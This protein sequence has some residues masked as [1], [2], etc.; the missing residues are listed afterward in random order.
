MQGSQANPGYDTVIGPEGLERALMDLYEQSQKDPV[1]AAEGHY[2]IYQFGQQKSLIKI[3]MSA[4]PYKF[5]YYDLWGR[6]ATSVVK[7]TIAQFLLDKESEK[8]GGQL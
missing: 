5:W 6:P 4:H 3:D 8:E 2:I 1:F 7:E